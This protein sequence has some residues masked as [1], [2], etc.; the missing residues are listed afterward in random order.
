MKV[1]SGILIL[2]KIRGHYDCT[3]FN[4]TASS[5]SPIIPDDDKGRGEMNLLGYASHPVASP[6]GLNPCP[7]RICLSSSDFF[8]VF[9]SSRSSRFKV[10]SFQIQIKISPPEMGGDGTGTFYF[11]LIVIVRGLTASDFGR[12]T[13]KIP[14]SNS[15]IALS[16]W[17]LTGSRTERSN[18]PWRCSRMW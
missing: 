15:A 13:V 14:F 6:A 7:R 2:L 11:G 5:V 18:E 16:V 1:I 4:P 17:T 8:V 3:P 9:A 12:V 10:E